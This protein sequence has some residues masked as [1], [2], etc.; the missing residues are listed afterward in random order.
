[1]LGY[2]NKQNTEKR[3]FFF[4]LWSEIS[5]SV[6]Q[7]ALH[8]VGFKDPPPQGFIIVRTQLEKGKDSM[9][10]GAETKGYNF[11]FPSLPNNYSHNPTE[12]K[13]V[14]ECRSIIDTK[15]KKIKKELWRA[16]YMSDRQVDSNCEWSFLC[17][18]K[19]DTMEIWGVVAEAMGGKRMCEF[20]LYHFHS[21]RSERERLF[22][23]SWHSIFNTTWY[24]GQAH[25]PRF[26]LGNW[27][28][29]TF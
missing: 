18:H 7:S 27:K 14:R 3:C 15:G 19:Q 20:I 2:L 21:L 24:F 10:R 11:H 4:T 28:N 12:M 8:Y 29:K 22:G 5:L 25:C 16:W 9:G 23:L 1:M 17:G 26:L 6:W 13:W